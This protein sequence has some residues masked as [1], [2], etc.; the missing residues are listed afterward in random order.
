M[1]PDYK[2]V[3]FF[4]SDPSG[5]RIKAAIEDADIKG[6]HKVYYTARNAGKAIL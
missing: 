3:I 1:P 4:V 5:H 2:S 6:K